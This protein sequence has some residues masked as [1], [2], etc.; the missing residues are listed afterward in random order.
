M[1]ETYNGPGFYEWPVWVGNTAPLRVGLTDESGAIDLTGSVIVLTV[2]W[3]DGS[4]SRR[5]DDLTGV[6]TIL[7]QVAPETR[8]YVRIT[9][10]PATTRLLPVGASIRY[11]I[12]RRWSGL[13][14]TYLTGP[15]IAQTENNTDG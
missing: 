13:E 3:L 11:E 2:T 8:G 1:S 14:R 9:F 6:V 10:T 4:L 12:E 5:S 7:D 15:I